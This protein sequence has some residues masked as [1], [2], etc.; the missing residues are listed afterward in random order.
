MFIRGFGDL[1]F[2]PL[3]VNA[4]HLL[5]RSRAGA[6]GEHHVGLVVR[7]IEF[8]EL[9]Q[10]MLRLQ[11]S[12]NLIALDRRRLCVD[13][14][15][16]RFHPEL[17]VIFE[18]FAL[19]Q[20]ALFIVERR[21]V[22]ARLFRVLLL[23]KTD[24][25]HVFRK[26]P[27]RLHVLHRSKNGHFRLDVLRIDAGRETSQA[28]GAFIA[29]LSHFGRR[30]RPWYAQPELVHSQVD[31][32]YLHFYLVALTEADRGYPHARFVEE[33]IPRGA[34]IDESAE[35]RDTLDYP[36]D[37]LSFLK[38]IQGPRVVAI[39][40]AA[41]AVGSAH[42]VHLHAIAIALVPRIHREGLCSPGRFRS[43]FK[44]RPRVF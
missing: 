16:E 1:Q 40:S 31:R 11:D 34:D 14:Q 38:V 6:S 39:D 41:S 3:D 23:L 26:S 20:G 25:C 24:V 8:N 27:T 33:A 12:L 42:A 10:A 4:F 44:V 2:R 22:V 5:G 17:Q 35:G 36:F 13:H 30:F 29:V 18:H 28:H 32:N 37:Y 43:I 9:H 15:Q 7:G 19:P 21:R